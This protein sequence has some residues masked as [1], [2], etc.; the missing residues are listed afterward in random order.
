MTSQATKDSKLWSHFFP[1]RLKIQEQQTTPFQ[2]G[3]IRWNLIQICLISY[4]LKLQPYHHKFF[5]FDF[6]GMKKCSPPKKVQ[7]TVWTGGGRGEISWITNWHQLLLNGPHFVVYFFARFSEK[8]KLRAQTLYHAQIMADCKAMIS[9]AAALPFWTDIQK[10]QIFPKLNLD[11]FYWAL[12]IIKWPVTAIPVGEK[13][14]PK[15][16]CGEVFNH[17]VKWKMSKADFNTATKLI[18]VLVFLSNFPRT[19]KCA[20]WVKPHHVAA[21]T[22][23]TALDTYLKWL[24]RKGHFCKTSRIL[25]NT[26]WGKSVALMMCQLKPESLYFLG[27]YIGQLVYQQMFHLFPSQSDGHQCCDS[28]P[29]KSLHHLATLQLV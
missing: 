12:M 4:L 14:L 22:A 27:Q 6:F 11:E 9:K 23:Q 26:G 8:P 1:T 29:D 15:C 7:W 13:A 5:S 3:H 20:V 24:D 21:T 16:Y 17:L 19:I 25:P 28:N 18:S 10:F 2:A